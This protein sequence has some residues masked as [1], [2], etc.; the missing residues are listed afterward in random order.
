MQPRPPVDGAAAGAEAGLYTESWCEERKAYGQ[1]LTVNWRKRHASGHTLR[2][3]GM[4]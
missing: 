2:T 1:M 4:I 3:I